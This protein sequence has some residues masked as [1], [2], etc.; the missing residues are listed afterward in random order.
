MFRIGIRN[1][2]ITYFYLCM[3]DCQGEFR[4]LLPAQLRNAAVIEVWV[5]EYQAFLR[6]ECEIVLEVAL[7]Q[8]AEST[9]PLYVIVALARVDVVSQCDN[10]RARADRLF[11]YPSIM[12]PPNQ[13]TSR[14][15]ITHRAWVVGGWICDGRIEGVDISLDIGPAGCTRPADAEIQSESRADLEVILHKKTE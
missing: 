15:G 13:M 3:R 4:G 1:I 5:A 14:S 8:R 11:M 6:S 12:R 9:A 2:T 7:T 10:W